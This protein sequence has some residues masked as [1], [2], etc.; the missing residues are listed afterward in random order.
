VFV[1]NE[2]EPIDGRAIP[3]RP[4]EADSNAINHKGKFSVGDLRRLRSL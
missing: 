2:V 3:W 4:A 1:Y